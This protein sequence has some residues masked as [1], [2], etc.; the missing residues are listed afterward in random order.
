MKQYVVELG[1][2]GVNVATKINAMLA[3][4]PGWRMAGATSITVG[5]IGGPDV[6]ILVTF[7]QREGERADFVEHAGN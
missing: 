6:H 3:R 2:L 1:T 5:R 4:N 7:E